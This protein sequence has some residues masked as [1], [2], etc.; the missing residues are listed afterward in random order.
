MKQ[1][2]SQLQQ[3]KFIYIIKGEENQSERNNHGHKQF[4]SLQAYNYWFIPK[5]FYE[6]YS[7]N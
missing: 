3:F 1:I 6:N 5:Y 4:V 7:N 2:Q